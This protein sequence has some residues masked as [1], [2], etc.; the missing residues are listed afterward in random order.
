MGDFLSNGRELPRREPA[1]GGG[2][3]G[4]RADGGP[5]AGAGEQGEADGT[6]GETGAGREDLPG[7]G[8]GDGGDRPSQ[9][10]TGEFAEALL[11]GPELGKGLRVVSQ[12]QQPGPLLWGEQAVEKSGTPQG[13]LL[14]VHPHLVPVQGTQGPGSAVA[15]VEAELGEVRKKGLSPLSTGDGGQLLQIP[16]LPQS[17]SQKPVGLAPVRHAVQSVQHHG[18]HLLRGILP[19]RPLKVMPKIRT[20]RQRAPR[21]AGKR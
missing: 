2:A 7:K 3:A 6:E 9:T 11:Q 10:Q 21:Q 14:D 5:P 8:D 4:R 19:H 16:V 13:D 1:D 17:H 15:E 18:P 12:P 20:G